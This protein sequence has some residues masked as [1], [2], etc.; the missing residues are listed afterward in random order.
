MN[1]RENLEKLK[2]ILRRPR[3]LLLS[4]SVAL[5]ALMFY[6]LFNN[7]GILERYFS[8]GNFS[9]AVSLIPSISARYFQTLPTAEILLVITISCLIGLNIT[10]A[11]FRLLE[12]SEFGR[13][14]A[15][16]LTGA[17]VATFAPAC[18]ACAGA[19]VG[20]TGASSL[21][22]IIPFSGYSIRIAAILLLMASTVYTLN[23]LGTKACK[24]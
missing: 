18:T 20:L 16:S 23:Q 8:E 24:I 11:A 19:V 12:L 22:A 14:N 1:P 6:S 15:S 10:L 13:E 17:A 3:Y 5:G 21:I 2:D 4:F 7:A 9:L